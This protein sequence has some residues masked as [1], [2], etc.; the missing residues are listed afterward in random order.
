MQEKE[1]LLAEF[2]ATKFLE[3]SLSGNLSSPYLVGLSNVTTDFMVVGQ[4]TN[5]WYYSMDKFRNHGIAE[6]IKIYDDF[7]EEF[8]GKVRGAFH[9]YVKDIF[10]FDTKPTLNNLFKFDLGDKSKIKSIARADNSI[11]SKLIEFHE[12]I[13]KTEIEILQPKTIVFFTGSSYEW[14]L[15]HFLP[16]TK[17]IVSGF[18][19]NELCKLYLD[20]FPNIKAY[21]TYHPSYL[22]RRYYTLGKHVKDYLKDEISKDIK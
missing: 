19:H 15:N 14:Y 5:T 22:N 18:R 10:G 17:E 12:G 2:Y 21:R 13:L 20:D 7:V 1:R 11:K 8:Y 9:R 4:E 16:N 3:N 6:Q